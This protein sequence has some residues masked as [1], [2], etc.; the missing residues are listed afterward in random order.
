MCAWAS[1]QRT[2]PLRAS[3]ARPTGSCPSVCA[4]VIPALNS[5]SVARRPTARPSPSRMA[6]VMPAR[7]ST[8]EVAGGTAGRRSA[9]AARA[10]PQPARFAP[11]RRISVRTVPRSPGCGMGE[12]PAPC[13][14]LRRSSSLTVSTRSSG[15]I[16]GSWS[17]RTR[18][19]TPFT[20]ARCTPPTRIS[21]RSSSRAASSLPGRCAPRSR[22]SSRPGVMTV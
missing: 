17:I 18:P 19:R 14:P 9:F 20:S 5:R 21:S 15:R 12:K 2:T 16:S 6:G 13:S 8:V 4:T 22:T 3:I 10:T 1:A 7:M 11:T